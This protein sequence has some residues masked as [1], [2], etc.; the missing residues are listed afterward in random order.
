MSQDYNPNSIDATLAKIL[1]NQE[2]HGE[3]LVRIETQ[4]AKTN[5][6]VDALEHDKWYV[7]GVTATIGLLAPGAWE[8]FKTR[9]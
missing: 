5:G 2:K 9:Q 8:W 3:T 7:R 6:R 4:A 1:A